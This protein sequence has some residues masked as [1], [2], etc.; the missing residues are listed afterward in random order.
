[1]LFV[2][3]I[4]I[5]IL[6]YQLLVLYFHTSKSLNI[7][8]FILTKDVIC[9]AYYDR[10]SVISTFGVILSH[11]QKF[12]YFFFYTYNK[13]CYLFRVF[14]IAVHTTL[15]ISKII[16]KM[17]IC[18]QIHPKISILYTCIFI[19]VSHVSFHL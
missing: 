2:S 5:D 1:M 12:E 17:I 3:R 8:S 11:K 13:C 18:Y 9:F 7:S 6:L 15:A 19:I 14:C 16:I 10:H 4:M